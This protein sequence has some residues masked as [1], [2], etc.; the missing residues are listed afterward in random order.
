M[1][2]DPDELGAGPALIKKHFNVSRET[3]ARL[4]QFTIL[5]IK[6]QRTTNLISHGSI[7]DIWERHM[8]D[9][10]QLY[11]HLISEGPLVDLGSGGGFPGIVLG[12]LGHKNITLIES[13]K[14]KCVFLREACRQLKLSLT[15]H[16]GRIEDYKP[17]TRFSY[18]TS[19]A[20]APLDN[21]LNFSK[22][23]MAKDGKCLFHKGKT[24]ASELTAAKKKWIILYKEHTSLSN[25]EGTILEIENFSLIE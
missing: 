11:R 21:L 5:L 19:R 7:A 9:S 6:W 17:A 8:L 20:L 13:N 24:V 22:P 12:I 15:V 3:L 14:K 10:A 23:L 18:I 4:E 25:R 1:K 16:E 2:H